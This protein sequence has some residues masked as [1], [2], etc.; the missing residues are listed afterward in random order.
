MPNL[1]DAT[2][3]KLGIFISIKCEIIHILP[4]HKHGV[5][6]TP[7]STMKPN[8]IYLCMDFL[9]LYKA[10]KEAI[11]LFVNDIVGMLSLK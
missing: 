2:Y 10:K 11:V 5:R 8:K 9:A 4:K 3:D 6:R 1:S 7:L